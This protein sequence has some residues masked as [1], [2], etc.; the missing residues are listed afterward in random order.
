MEQLFVYG[1]LHEP[2]VQLRL[3]GRLLESRPD[4]LV[5]YERNMSLLPPYPVAMPKETAD[6]QGHVLQVTTE[7][8]AL[9]DSY[10]TDAYERIRVRLASGIDSWV[11]IG[12][13]S[14]FA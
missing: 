1:T 8:L 14:Y 13:P 4:R 5:G 3:I 12:N 2:E 10:E 9:F 11:Y 6:I 7:E